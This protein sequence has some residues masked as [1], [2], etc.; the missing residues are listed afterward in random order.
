MMVRV[1]HAL[2]GAEKDAF[3]PIGPKV[4]VTCT[5]AGA[6]ADA[7]LKVLVATQNLYPVAACDPFIP[8]SVAPPEVMPEAATVVGDV[9]PDESAEVVND[10]TV[11][12]T[13][14]PSISTHGA[15]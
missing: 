7:V 14:T 11:P 2:S 10:I 9:V 4:P 12:G 15:K 8:F 13:H 6:V 5:P 3:A 1:E